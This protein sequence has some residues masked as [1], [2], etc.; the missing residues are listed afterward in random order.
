MKESEIPAGKR[1]FVIPGRED[2]FEQ[3]G[4]Y[5]L[6]MGKF[7]E[8]QIADKICVLPNGTVSVL[9]GVLD[10]KAIVAAAGRILKEGRLICDS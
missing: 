9:S 6:Y 7:Y 5:Y 3:D 1:K 8:W 10:A 4:K 2:V